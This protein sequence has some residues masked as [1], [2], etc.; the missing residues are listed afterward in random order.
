M[1]AQLLLV[2]REALEAALITA[3]ILAYLARTKRKPLI[4]YVWYGVYLAVAAS[5]VFGAFVWFIYG[6]LS[7]PSKALFEGVAAL[8]AVFVLSYMIYWMAGKG[9]ELRKE[10][11]R[12]VK[13][14]VH[15]CVSY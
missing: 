10:V 14:L 9:K 4:R 2:F 7:G 6:A 12:R 1:F 11:E 8:F 15:A 3:I 13:A 5:F